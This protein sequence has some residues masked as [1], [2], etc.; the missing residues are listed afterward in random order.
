MN[1]LE[2]Q[3]EQT[4]GIGKSISRLVSEAI[5]LKADIISFFLEGDALTASIM[6]GDQE[7][8]RSGMASSW[9]A[10]LLAWLGQRA[11][12]SFDQEAFLLGTSGA[13][14]LEFSSCLRLKEE[15]VAFKVKRLS[16]AGREGKKGLRLSG[17][18][19]LAIERVHQVL[20]LTG[21]ARP[22]YES[23]LSGDTG[24]M[25]LASPEEEHL[26]R[27]VSLTLATSERLYLGDLEQEGLKV[28]LP[29]LAAKWPLVVSIRSDDAV[30]ALLR[31][32]TAGCDV[33]AC[34]LSGVLCQGLVRGICQDCARESIP[35][36]FLIKQLPEAL[37]P[38]ANLSY[39]VGRG[40]DACKSTGYRGL[41]SVQNMLAPG[42][43][44]L[45]MLSRGAAQ[46]Q[47]VD[48]LYQRGLR[49]LLQD[50]T[51]KV[52][53]GLLTYESLFSLTKTVPQAY[54][55]HLDHAEPE[56]PEPTELLPGGIDLF[57]PDQGQISLRPLSGRAVFS[58]EPAAAPISITTREKPLLLV[59]EDDA[60]QSN[61]LQMVL[62]GERYDVCLAADGAEGLQRVERDLPD[63]IIT[64][65][66]M[67]R[68]DGAE[69]VRRLKADV[70]FRSIPVLVLTVVSDADR[71]CSL[72]DLGADDYCEKTVQKKVLL[73]RI[74]G[75]L[76]RRT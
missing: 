20:G 33:Q 15:L 24:L 19:V 67:P 10:P 52:N 6:K 49:P 57:G 17:F 37:K 16:S 53:K 38:P 59:V 64:D 34:N 43:E 68:I 65:L 12:I 13:E 21:N 14:G 47:I 2:T 62:R 23:I 32:S 9:Y 7:L 26:K 60:D 36:R 25:L 4:F 5:Y 39:L 31:F 71:E 61:I 18:R 73:K 45:D 72:L 76:R 30:E 28:L 66:M 11:L 69:F 35:D 63:L 1:N 75:L 41:I 44:V 48:F 46:P 70:R 40:C 55:K 51:R 50:G 74:E 54:V 56:V 3:L 8:K 29:A 58:G 27:A 42:R 22:Q